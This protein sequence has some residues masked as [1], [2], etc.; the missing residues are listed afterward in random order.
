M[1]EEV[2][3][4]AA[5]IEAAP[6]VASASDVL[7]AEPAAAESGGMDT[8]ATP[9]ADAPSSW[10]TG[11][12]EDE[13][14]FIGNKGWD[15]SENPVSE[16]LKSYQ[17]GERL[18]GVKAD[19]LVR[20]PEL[21]NEEQAAEFRARMGV[22]EAP[23]GYESPSL[24]VQGQP[25]DSSL[26]AAGHHEAGLTPAQ[27][28]AVSRANAAVLENA[29]KVEFDAKNAKN[30]AEKIEL[31]NE[32][33]PVLEENQLA[34]RRGFETLEFA[35]EVI[36]AL[37]NAIGYKETMK[38]GALVGRMSGEH[39]RGDDK[40]DNS[41]A[42]AFGLTPDAAKQQIAL[43]G[44]ELMA[45]ANKGDKSAAAELKRLNTVAYHS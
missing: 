22:P 10:S 45:A 21:G 29:I 11:L 19:Q 4:P 34:A 37:E 8:A 41:N 23:D 31:D 35:P 3:A 24:E 16:M 33:G 40:S 20:I 32:W 36:D 39:K 6:A 18:R 17:N 27:H 28:E 12:S 25:F 2:A 43:K 30:S 1:S 15:K 7:A 13:I 14:G 44:G 5:P 26:F 42:L 38:L 9:A